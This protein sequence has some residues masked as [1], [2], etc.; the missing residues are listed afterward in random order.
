MHCEL[1]GYVTHRITAKQTNI[2][3]ILIDLPSATSF[4]L[5]RFSLRQYTTKANFNA[6][7][8]KEDFSGIDIKF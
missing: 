4:L 3:K 5:E 6:Q 1:N 8:I 2:M 7:K